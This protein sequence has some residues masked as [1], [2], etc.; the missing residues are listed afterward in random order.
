MAAV[1]PE[2]VVKLPNG[3]YKA[4]YRDA[5]DHVD[6]VEITPEDLEKMI[7]FGYETFGYAPN[8]KVIG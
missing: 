7:A 8:I 5:N 4:Y 1:F 6:T 3:N 2:T